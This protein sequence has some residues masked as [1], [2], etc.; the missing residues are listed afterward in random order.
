MRFT[1]TKLAGAFVIELEPRLDERGFFARTFCE[2]EFAEHGLPTRFPQCNLS[3]NRSRGTLRG[4]HYEAP[5]SAESKLVRCLTGAIFDVIVDLRPGSATRFAWTGVELSGE[6]GRALF[7][8]AGFAHGFLTLKDDSDV[9]YHMGDSYRP[10]AARGFRW[11]DPLF[12][13][14]WPA[15]PSSIAERDANYP[16]YEPTA[17]SR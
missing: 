2:R 14:E 5:P 11:D 4:M 8:P 1:E 15:A 13:I 7:V 16:D 3:R 6:T 10:D 12:A 9:F 17:A